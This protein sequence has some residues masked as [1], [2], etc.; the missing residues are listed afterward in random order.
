MKK[1]CTFLCLSIL[2]TTPLTAYAFEFSAQIRNWQSQY[3]GE[4]G[5][6]DGSVTLKSLGYD[7][8]SYNFITLQLKHP[9]IFLPNIRFQ[10]TTMSTDASAT[11]SSGDV[12]NL[13]GI[14]FQDTVSSELDLSHR[15][16]TL[17]Y[18]PLSNWIRL[19]VGLTGR[20]FS[21]GAEASS[22]TVNESSNVELNTWVPLLYGNARFDLPLTGLYTGLNTN[23][24]NY[25]GHSLQ[26][27]MA[28]V[29]YTTSG[30]TGFNVE[31]G[32]RSFKLNIDGLDDLEGNIKVDG[33][34][35]G[36]G[37]IF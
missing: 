6:D 3:S 2:T 20:Y 9:I 4:L 21:G 28:T 27:Y 36:V 35:L 10:Q 14:D 23:M 30:I 19:D 29:G 25:D 7:D 11:L 37:L 17:F 32:Y 26:D 33:Y 24:L 18:S 15:D 12:L 1:I 34:F 31:L 5:S 22:E 13:D 16:I 8:E